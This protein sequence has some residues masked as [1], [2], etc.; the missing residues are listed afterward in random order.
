MS[1]T[2]KKTKTI[3]MDQVNNMSKKKKNEF[4][5]EAIKMQYYKD[6][7][8]TCS[9]CAI[10]LLFDHGYISDEELSKIGDAEREKKRKTYHND[11]YKN[12]FK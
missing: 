9:Q 2:K 8:I 3:S 6:I 12:V 4:L 1:E 7:E 10:N 11:F 5:K